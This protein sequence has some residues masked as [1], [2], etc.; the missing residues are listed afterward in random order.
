M[1]HFVLLLL[2]Q[3]TTQAV[4][5]FPI[6]PQTL[7]NLIESSAYIVIAKVDNP[8]TKKGDFIFTLMKH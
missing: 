4:V 5:A 3:F 1:K 8:G 7:R 6:E 2:L